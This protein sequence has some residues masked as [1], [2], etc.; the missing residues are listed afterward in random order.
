MWLAQPHTHAQTR[1]RDWAEIYV[2]TKHWQ[3]AVRY[4]MKMEHLAENLARDPTVVVA[5]PFCLEKA[6][7]AK[8]RSIR[9]TT[10]RE[11]PAGG[12]SGSFFEIF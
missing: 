2:P 8:N 10:L 4:G 1:S 12:G 5:E 11:K 9:Q 7:S 6:E 3:K